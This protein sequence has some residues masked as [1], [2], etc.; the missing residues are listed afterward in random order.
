MKAL[1]FAA[2]LTLA[3]SVAADSHHHSHSHF[4]SQDKR[5]SYKNHTHN[6]NEKLAISAQHAS[7]RPPTQPLVEVAGGIQVNTS[8]AVDLASTNTT[9]LTNSRKRNIQGTSTSSTILIIARDSASAYSGYSGLNGYAIPYQVLIVPKEGTALPPLNSSTTA[10]NFG[11][12]VILSEVS[13]DYGGTL[14]FQSALTTDQWTTLYVYQLAFGVRMVRI[15]VYPSSATGTTALGACCGSGVEQ[16]LTINDTAGF[17][18]AGL[19]QGST[20]ST[21]NMYHYPAQITNSMIAKP[22]LQFAVA[23]GFSTVSTGGVINNIN[24]RQQM[25]FFIPFATDWNAGSNVLQHSWIHWATRGVYTGYRRLYFSTQ[26]DDM[27][28]IIPIG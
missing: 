26:I 9:T 25:V 8:S 28:L 7:H 5:G 19:K 20:I 3:I 10:G 15:D 21:V 16:L 14:G 4:H 24:G 6:S 13:Y 11:A 18:T 17:P 2:G 22:F 27:F 23:S 1:N 12:I